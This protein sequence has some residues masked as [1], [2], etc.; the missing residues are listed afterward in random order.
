M[1]IKGIVHPEMNISLKCTH[2]QTRADVSLEITVSKC[3]EMQGLHEHGMNQSNKSHI[4]AHF[5]PERMSF[6]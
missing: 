4:D 3:I 2:P 6:S 5:D 1:Q